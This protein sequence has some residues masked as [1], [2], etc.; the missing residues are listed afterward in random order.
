[1]T[2]CKKQKPAEYTVLGRYTPYENFPEKLVAKV[3]KIKEIN[4]WAVPRGDTYTRGDRITIKDRDS[5]NWTNDFEAVYDNSGELVR[6]IFLDENNSTYRLRELFKENN[7]TASL[8]YT[9]AD[10][11]RYIDKITYNADGDISEISN[12]RASPDTLLYKGIFRYSLK[13]DTITEHWSDYNGDPYAR[14]NEIYNAE[15]Q[16]IRKEFYDEKGNFAGAVGVKY[17]DKGKLSSLTAFD[18]DKNIYSV[19]EMTYEYDTK[20]NWVK[21]I[22]TDSESGKV[23]YV[24]RTYS[25]FD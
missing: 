1:M 10:T 14:I 21:A 24:E 17:N 9:R 23:I 25:Y 12:L 19:D 13:K 16:F 20:G 6:C 11:L 4:Y 8:K 18:K 5:L 7:L 3:E 22:V 2:A 15:G